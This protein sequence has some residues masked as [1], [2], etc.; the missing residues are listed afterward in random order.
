MS[1]TLSHRPLLAAALFMHL[2]G[3]ADAQTTPNAVP[4]EEAVEPYAVSPAN[5]GATPVKGEDLF[6]A[7]HGKAGVD[8]I[9]DVFVDRNISDP[10]ISDIFKASDLVRTRRTLKEQFCFILNGGCEYT[11]RDM[12][13]AHK[14]LGL[15]ES[16]MGALVE[17]L[18]K[19]MDK[20]GVPFHAQNRLLSKLAPMKRD[21]VVR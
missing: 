9:V 6:Q 12:T 10:R 4:G 18:Q 8:R 16:D 15:Q 19:A 3:S 2:A 13:S 11:G 1:K 14:D 5:A 7:F 20:E 21:V 17:N